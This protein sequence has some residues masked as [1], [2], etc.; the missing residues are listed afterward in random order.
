ML[1]EGP[2]NTGDVTNLITLFTLLLT[3][4]LINRK[5]NVNYLWAGILMACSC[6]VKPTAL[7]IYLPLI[8]LFFNKSDSRFQFSASV[9]MKVV[10]GLLIPTLLLGSFLLLT[11]TFRGFWESLVLEPY[12]H[13]AHDKFRL[14][15]WALKRTIY[16]FIQDPLLRIGG[17][18]CLFFFRTSE[19]IRVF[20]LLVI[21]VLTMVILEGRLFP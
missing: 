14:S 18:A 20:R 2:G 3:S 12:L 5:K 8:F 10:L 1:I 11:G 9:F 16:H 19:A 13:Y 7:L 15:I 6:W 4:H 17:I 21:G